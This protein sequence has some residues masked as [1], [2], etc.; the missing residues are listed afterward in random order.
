MYRD[1][2][3]DRCE[4][5]Y[6]CHICPTGPTGPK[7]CPGEEGPTGP[8]GCLGEKGPTGPKGCPGEKGPTGPK[9][10]PGEKGPTGPKGHTG[11]TGPQGIQGSIGATGPTGAQGIQGIQGVQGDQGPIGPTGPQGG[12]GLTGATGPTGAQG[13]TGATGGGLSAYGYIFN[14]S[15]EVVP[16]EA[17]VTFSNNTNLVG[18]THAPGTSQIVLV[19]AGDYAIWFSVSGVEPNQFTLFL[20]GAAILGST[21]GSGAGTQINSGMVIVTAGAGDILTLRNH[22]SASA[23]TL[24]TLAGGTQVNTNASVLIEKLN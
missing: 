7:G 8:K 20:N 2:D 18:I 22:T 17:D 19:S 21:Y 14:L 13:A 9:G 10:C 3:D 1:D 12:Q 16:I 15:A 23:V 11:P 6:E 4:Y 24:Q 5:N